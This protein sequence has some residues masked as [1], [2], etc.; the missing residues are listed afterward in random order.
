MPHVHLSGMTGLLL[1]L[2]IIAAFG[3]MH[4][5]A[6]SAPDNKFARGWLALGF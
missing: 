1:V 3:S 2:F 6:A 4:L 5:L